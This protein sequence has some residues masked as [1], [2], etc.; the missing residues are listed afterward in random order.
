MKRFRNILFIKSEDNDEA[1]FAHAVAVAAQNDTGLTLV[2]TIKE[3]RNSVYGVPEKMVKELEREI[4]AS[5]KDALEQLAKPHQRSAPIEI[6]ILEGIPFISIIQDVL[7]ND[8]DLII[9]SAGGDFGPLSRLF[10]SADMHLL[11]KCPCPVWLI[12]PD[13]AEK[14]NRIVAA[15]DLDEAGGDERNSTLNKQILEMAISLAHQE[16]AEL[17]VVHAW[18][19]VAEN[20]L[21][22]VRSNMS[23][24][25]VKHFVGSVK[26]SHEKY[27][28]TL[29]L[30]AKN[31][32][33]ASVFDTVNPTSHVTKGP[34][35]KVVPDLAKSL[36]AD[37]VVMG[38]VGRTGIPGFLIGNTA[39]TILGSIDCSVLAVK[40]AGFVSPVDLSRE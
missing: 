7:R 12:K 33:G 16:G 34:A 39:E 5:C 2:K 25:Q 3:I 13:P 29:M 17:H 36:S 19:T 23:D 24:A 6:R 21:R 28:S 22:G 26:A 30:Q 37:L 1:A 9:K 27:L 11:R 32:V 14:T 40:P 15:V 8:I 38:T 31:W 35:Q 18:M 10:G 4:L 20:T